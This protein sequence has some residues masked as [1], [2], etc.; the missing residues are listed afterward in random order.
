MSIPEQQD[1]HSRYFHNK[2][3]ESG[4]DCDADLEAELKEAGITPHHLPEL[5]R[6]GE[7]QSVVVGSLGPWGFR[8]AWRYWVADGPGIP[9]KQAEIL[10]ITHGT[11]VRV[12]G[13]CECPPPS[14][15]QGFAVG[16]YHVDTREGLKALA[17]MIKSIM[18]VATQKPASA[19]T[20]DRTNDEIR[21]DQLFDMRC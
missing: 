9:P 21:L 12:E 4:T 5:L 16:M 14:Y 13:H 20:P 18:N 7:V 2:A 19:Q 3:G 6:R 17:T 10:H 15:C 8:R 11:Q 1:C